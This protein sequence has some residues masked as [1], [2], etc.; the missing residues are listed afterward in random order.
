MARDTRSNKEFSARTIETAR[1]AREQIKRQTGRSSK[2]LDSQCN[3]L[4]EGLRST[5]PALLG[6]IKLN[7][8]SSANVI[9][10]LGNA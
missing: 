8:R 6:R 4:R 7:P 1:W 2:F 10:A 5:L 9:Q 3:R